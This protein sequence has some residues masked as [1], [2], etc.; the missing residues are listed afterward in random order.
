MFWENKRELKFEFIGAM[1]RLYDIN[2]DDSFKEIFPYPERIHLG[3]YYINNFMN[4]CE[5]YDTWENTCEHYFKNPSNFTNLDNVDKYIQ[6]I[7]KYFVKGLNCFMYIYEENNKKEYLNIFNLKTMEH[8]RLYMCKKE[9]KMQNKED[10]DK[11]EFTL[12]TLNIPEYI[13]K[14]QNI[15][16]IHKDIKFLIKKHN[17]K[18]IDVMPEVLTLII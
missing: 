14:Y 8:V 3:I 9:L 15:K 11:I 4:F 2:Q 1:E 10:K 17:F 12:F 6:L 18:T 5:L 13:H 7:L 16:N